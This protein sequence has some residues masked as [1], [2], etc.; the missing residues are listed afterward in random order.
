MEFDAK[1]E[2][3]TKT[4][5]LVLGLTARRV[6]QLAQDGV[7]TAAGRGRYPLAGAVQEY[8]EYR[9]AEKPLSQAE[10]EKLNSEVV[11][12]KAKAVMMSMEAK[13]L[14]GKMHRAEDVANMTEDLIYATRSMLLALPGRLAV[15]A[16][17]V[18]DPAE[19]S[20]LIRREVYSVMEE[21]SQ[22]RY[23]SQKYEERVRQR[24]NWDYVDHEDEGGG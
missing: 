4:L 24:M 2:V 8:I 17:A 22:Y 16:A 13:E 6:Q 23:N 12:K 19:M 18:S 11:I 14:Q 10:T 5:A 15:D 1:M 20:E 3:N 7:I 21:L 9:A